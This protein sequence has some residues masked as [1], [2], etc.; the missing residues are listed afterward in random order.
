MTL[1]LYEPKGRNIEK[2]VIQENVINYFV[3]SKYLVTAVEFR[4]GVRLRISVD[5]KTF[6]D[7][8]YPPDVD[9]T[10]NSFTVLESTTGRLFLNVN[11]ED[12]KYKI[13]S[14]GTL[15]ISNSDGTYYNKALERTNVSF[16]GIVDFEKVQGVE[17]IILV[18][19]ASPKNN[20]P[21]T[22]ISFDDG[23]TW[24]PIP[25]PYD[26]D[27][28][29][30]PCS[31]DDC[32]LN[33]HSHSSIENSVSV[34]YL[35]SNPSATG[36]LLG[37][38]NV[39]PNLT[40]INNADTYMSVD[41]GL[42]WKLVKK[43]VYSWEFID[44]GSIIVLIQ[45][46]VPTNVLYYSTNYGKDWNE[47]Q[48]LNTDKIF[49]RTL[50]SD[51]DS[52]SMYAFILGYKQG[53]VGQVVS[54]SVNFEN[55]LKKKCSK[56]DFEEWKVSG[57]GKKTCLL[58]HETTY[59]RK[60][61][62][63]DCYVGDYE[64]KV[65]KEN[66]PCSEIDYECDFSY[67][68]DPY[69]KCVLDGVDPKQPENCK[70]GEVFNGSSG[71]RK[72]AASTCTGSFKYDEPVKRVCGE[73]NSGSNSDIVRKEHKIETIE[74]WFYFEDSETIIYL[75]KYYELFVSRNEGLDWEPVAKDEKFSSIIK[76][77]NH[78]DLAI[79]ITINSNTCYY[80]N[81]KGKNFYSFELPAAANPLKIP[82]FS[83]NPNNPGWWLFVGA[84]DCKFSS[85]FSDG[86]CH[87]ILYL[88]KNY[89]KSWDKLETYV[90]HCEWARTEKFSKPDKNGIFCQIHKE[91]K[92]NMAEPMGENTLTLQYSSDFF[93][94]SKELLQNAVAF[95]IFDKYMMVAQVTPQL[96][97]QAKLFIS[98]DGSLFE[99]AQFPPNFKVPDTGFTI[100]E[101]KTGKIFMDIFT[102]QTLGSE[103]GFLFMSSNNGTRF[104]P[105]L[106]NTNR[107][108]YGYVDFEKMIGIP[109]IAIANIVANPDSYERSKMVQT[110][111]SFNDGS[112]WDYVKA[113]TEDCYGK[114]FDCD[115]DRDEDCH[116][117]FH[118]YTER[119]E[120][121][122]YFSSETAIGMM[123]GIGNVGKYLE[124]YKDSDTF[125]T[126][127]AGKTWVE[128]HKDAHLYEFGDYGG[129]LI[130][131]NDEVPT[132][133]L[134]FSVDQG[135]TFTK[136]QFVE[137]KDRKVRVKDILTVPDGT[138][139]KFL[140]IGTIIDNSNDSGS[141]IMIY[142]DFAPIKTN[143]CIINYQNPEKSDFELWSP[144][145]TDN[146]CLL[147]EK[148]EFYRRKAG[149]D[150]YMAEKFKDPEFKSASCTCTE[151]DYECDFNFIRSKGYNG[152]CELI[153]G[154][155]TPVS[156]CFNGKYYESTGYRLI[157]SSKCVSGVRLDTEGAKSH[158]CT[159]GGSSSMG[160]GTKI[161]IVGIPL[162]AA[163]FFLYYYK[164]QDWRQGAIRL[165]T[166][167]TL[168][169]RFDLS[170]VGEA[171]IVIANK[172]VDRIV[173]L[174]DFARNII[175]RRHD[176]APL[177][178][179][180]NSEH[181]IFVGN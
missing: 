55:I 95:A 12:S 181:N 147:G 153:K 106:Q 125:L 35:Y 105:C 161:V 99:E 60:K 43:G 140:L 24:N 163:G 101:S 167:E 54:T 107:N 49:L 133:F 79:F 131:V 27:N 165:P 111:M 59:Q 44:Q 31:K 103:H 138:S 36:I 11:K 1:M 115:P 100:L 9:I 128:I 66:C 74:D 6:T 136:Y 175:I 93:K 61:A 92:G 119:R 68:R 41:A 62:D 168:N 16:G 78:K 39:G 158:W 22:V 122:N 112:T 56:S 141:E 69:G 108:S 157:P 15:Y 72:I 118:S 73:D 120:P 77:Q 146:G 151:M 109:G 159:G 160:S 34:G 126:R 42:T 40:D 14:F 162:I 37:V 117:H 45:E 65:S 137:Q 4:D 88:T 38:G 110:L 148:L 132:N 142:L 64:R 57:N 139:L 46:D 23:A 80:T 26:F 63:S 51:P 58:G 116:L 33:L 143:K 114:K 84:E 90:R 94:H 10:N 89:G 145:I 169:P 113:P 28:R 97:D 124:K 170:M 82:V 166:D 71:Y 20:K 85:F 87:T 127:D 150:C 172:V 7:A 8:K 104:S 155:V 179:N 67:W 48:F 121:R 154:A 91:R 47:Y 2:K 81:D 178:Y 149:N 52:K 135:N 21:R 17:G 134:E 176:Y 30:V 76:S 171:I 19:E 164:A 130:L 102:R 152:T 75:N 129:I 53:Q 174:Y 96:R 144:S 18:N 3:V 29:K 177:N 83:V 5:G 70:K 156:Q 98:T 32:R 123:V 25:R 173:S 50:T 13:T 86:D 180:T